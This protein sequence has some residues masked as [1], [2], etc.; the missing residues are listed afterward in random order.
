MS[1]L[2]STFGVNPQRRAAIDRVAEKIRKVCGVNTPVDTERLV[3]TLG[4]HLEEQSGLDYEAQIV[5]HNG[6]FTIT[7]DRQKPS[8]R[9]TF[10]IAHEIGHLVLHMGFLLD[11]STWE[12]SAT[13][14][15][16]V[17]YRSGHTEEEREADEFAAA[18]LMPRDEFVKVAQGHLTPKGY[19]V[20][21]I[22]AHFRV[23][24]DA[25]L[26]RGRWLGVFRWE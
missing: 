16:S 11:R 19:N 2:T 7:L 5:R 1:V 18:L 4:G 22:A 14:T 26:T 24:D 6:A 9:K 12:R 23:S 25:A 13:F 3:H 8:L 21:K 15:D 17:Y 10:S 20:P